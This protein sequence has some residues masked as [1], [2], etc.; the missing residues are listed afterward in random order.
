VTTVV[1]ERQAPVTA[2]ALSASNVTVRFGGLV[3][4]A[5]VAIEVPPGT[6]VGLVGPNGA[7]KST[8]FGVLSGLLRPASGRVFIGGR[9]VTS[10]SPQSRAR[11]GLARTF[12]QPELFMGL[13]VRDH[14]VLGHRVRY[15]RRRLWS[16]LVDFRALFPPSASET[17][18]VKALLDLLGLTDVAD[19]PVAILPLGLARLVEVGR[20]MATRP[21]VVLLD[22]PLSGLDIR[23]TERLTAVFARVVANSPDG[24]SLLMV[25]HDVASVLAL[26]SKIFVLDFGHLIAEGTPSE[27]RANTAVRAA[28]LGDEDATAE[29]SAVPARTTADRP[30][31]DGGSPNGQPG[32]E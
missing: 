24:L 17:E 32:H 28:Y 26:S 6:I 11:L 16:D 25:E 12:Q 4:L 20:A 3:A 7:G 15:E 5:D 27:I 1:D 30:R 19:T 8:L 31:T 13:T 21:S 10:S 18:Q 23:A 9:D 2:P 29:G 14:L 22:E